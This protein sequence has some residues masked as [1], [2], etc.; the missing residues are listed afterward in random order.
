MFRLYDT[1]EEYDDRKQSYAFDI[2]KSSDLSHLH[3]HTGADGYYLDCPGNKYLLR[4]PKVH[5]FALAISVRYTMLTNFDTDVRIHF[6]YD[7]R[8]R[9]GYA[10]ELEWKLDGT[11]AAH[12]LRIADVHEERISTLDVGHADLAEGQWYPITVKIK[13][14]TLQGSVAGVCFAMQIPDFERGLVGLQR[15][16]FIGE[17]IIREM[18]FETE[19][20]FAEET[21]LAE[22]SAEIPLLF[23][24]KDPYTLYWRVTRVDG[25][26]Y[27][28]IRLDGG[29]YYRRH[30][31]P[32]QYGVEHDNFTGAYIR[33]GSQKWNLRGEK[34]TI[35]NQQ[36]VWECLK[37]FFNAADLPLERSWQ[38][39]DENF[40]D[41]AFG[42][43]YASVSGYNTQA[44]GPWE[45]AFDREGKPVYS[46]QP[47]GKDWFELKS[48][49]DKRAVQM[50]PK[51]TVR[52]EDV[53]DHFANNHYFAPDEPM[54]LRFIVHT[55]KKYITVKARFCDV[56]GKKLHD[57]A[58]DENLTCTIE[59]MP[60]GLYRIV[61]DVYYGEQLLES[62]E[63][64]LEVFDPTGKTCAPLVSGLP[65]LFSTPNEIK[66]LDRDPFDPWNPR[67]SCN[68][69][70]FY[71]CV[72]FTPVYARERR[73]WEITKLFGREWYVWLSNRTMPGDC[74]KREDL[75][76]EPDW[77]DWRD[78][79]ENCDYMYY[80]C[81]YGLYPLRND[82]WNP[83]AYKTGLTGEVENF[84]K[85][86]PD[87]ELSWKP[88]E[89]FVKKDVDEL[90]MKY[91]R[92]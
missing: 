46:G 14:T 73:T 32:G 54:K 66:G 80:E 47:A 4:T 70:H 92:L 24:G 2:E 57:V 59:P 8:E 20:E 48:P 5:D 64:V 91:H 29:T 87:V 17:W 84:M 19:E 16:R 39:E 37:T 62:P 83:S 51:E 67:H 41:I 23:G 18:A 3:A 50:I 1:F 49:A 58:L 36:I 78:I 43:S 28:N 13:G 85:A 72:C 52:Y 55:D 33:A 25:Q 12:L 27:L 6:G 69:E 65:F 21:I 79:V 42:F 22:Q 11:I 86:Y 44:G 45:F 7:R 10:L 61:Y 35:I 77:H 75:P 74:R 38:L 60:V 9:T 34:L 26:A 40:A 30:N 76:R 56:Y 53:V 90:L 81:P 82:Y 63:Y 68:A 89:P 88:G 31:F 71:A 15:G